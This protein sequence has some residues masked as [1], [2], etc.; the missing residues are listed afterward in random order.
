MVDLVFRGCFVRA[1]HSEFVFRAC[2]RIYLLPILGKFVR[3]H[4]FR[5][6]GVAAIY[7]TLHVLI[8]LYV[9]API[10]GEYWV[11]E[12]IGVHRMLASSIS[13]PRIVFLGGSSTLFGVDARQVEEETGERAFNMGMHAE[14]RLER[15]LSIGEETARRGDVLVLALEKIFYSCEQKLWNSWQVNNAL[16]WDRSYFDGLP[17]VTRISAIFSGGSP[18]LPAK[19]L[20]SKLGSTLF[21]EI[22]ADRVRALAPIDVI[23]ERYRSQNFRTDDFAYSAYN[24]DD[25]GDIEKNIGGTYI[26]AGVPANEPGNVCPDALSVLASFVA[27]MEEKRVRVVVAHTPYLIEG[28]PAAGWREAEANFARDIASTGATILDRREELFLPGAYFFDRILHLNQVGR[29]ERTRIMISDLRALGIGKGPAGLDRGGGQFQSI[30][31][32]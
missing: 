19:I 17:L 13:T 5:I 18:V 24:V 27:R 7:L 9:E 22:Y 12:L 25:R 4:F 29:R 31:L 1:V 8:C 21:P 26:G 16:A 23:W 11:R 32:Q 6:I 3:Q 28:V 14:M 30:K 20:I 15:V 10:P 2:L